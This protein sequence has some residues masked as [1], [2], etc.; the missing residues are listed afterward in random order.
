MQGLEN[1]HEVRYSGVTARALINTALL[2]VTRF[3]LLYPSGLGRKECAYLYYICVC[4][5]GKN[6]ECLYRLY[7]IKRARRKKNP[8]WLTVY[9]KCKRSYCRIPPNHSDRIIDPGDRNV[10]FS[11][12][13]L[14]LSLLLPFA[15]IRRQLLERNFVY[16]RL[17]T[18]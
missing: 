14:A 16:P 2:T 13:L 10:S 15:D 11:L 5:S 17:E 8:T 12:I 4:K 6:A 18:N 9:L 7:R 3:A 1:Y